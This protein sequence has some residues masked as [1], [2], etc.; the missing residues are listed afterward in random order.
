M[1]CCLRQ[2]TGFCEKLNAN[3]MKDCHIVHLS[4]TCGVTCNFATCGNEGT[5][6]SYTTLLIIASYQKYKYIAT[7]LV[8]AKA[9][10]IQL[11]T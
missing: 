11:L 9:T 8:H 2:I 1:N 3:F 10:C 7:L 6:A 5:L 4:P